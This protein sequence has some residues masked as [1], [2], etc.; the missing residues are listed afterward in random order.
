MQ[1][2]TP[3]TNTQ[4]CK[5]NNK[6]QE[7]KNLTL[8]HFPLACWTLLPPGE[9]I[10]NNYFYFSFDILFHK[11]CFLFFWY[12]ITFPLI[13]PIVF[14]ISTFSS[15]HLLCRF[16]A[17][18]T[19]MPLSVEDSSSHKKKSIPLTAVFEGFPF[20]IS[21][22]GRWRVLLGWTPTPCDSEQE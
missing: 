14:W 5:W 2:Y 7:N 3:K 18:H 11:I 20:F 16:N 1:C 22:W 19:L 4:L 9:H 15:T 13:R 17:R 21:L 10:W 12:C 8:T 6:A